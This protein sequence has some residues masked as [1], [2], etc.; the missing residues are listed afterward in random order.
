MNDMEIPRN[1]QPICSNRKCGIETSMSGPFGFMPR[2]L[3]EKL[4]YKD[5]K[6]IFQMKYECQECKTKYQKE[7]WDTIGKELTNSHRLQKMLKKKWLVNWFMK[8]ANRNPNLQELL[9]D[10]LHN[11]QSQDRFNS[12]WFLIKSLLF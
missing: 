12:K 2:R 4:L 11:K 1:G 10:M 8:K 5:D 3:S 7:L 9:T 6:G